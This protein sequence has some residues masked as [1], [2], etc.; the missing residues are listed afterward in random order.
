MGKGEKYY[1]SKILVI[2]EDGQHKQM[3]NGY[4]HIKNGVVEGLYQSLTQDTP[5]EDLGNVA[6]IPGFVNLHT[7]PSEVYGGKSYREDIGNPLFY[8]SSL[9]D[10]ADLVQLGTDSAEIQ[11]RLNLAELIKSGCTTALIFG[12]PN[13]KLEAELAGELGIRAYVGAGIRAGDANEEKSIWNSPDGYSLKYSF[14]EAEGFKRLAEAADSIKEYKNAWNGRVKFLLAPTQSMTCTPE[15]LKETRR[16]ADKLGVGITIHGAED[17]MEFE[18]AIRL[19]GKTPVELM[20]E[21][22]LLGE[23]L[24][25]A[26]CICITGHT[27][28]NI[29]GRDLALLGKS[30]STVA[31]CPW[32]LA[33]EGD[34][35]QSFAK[36]Q[37]AGVNMGIG[38]DTFPS[39]FIQEMRYAAAMGKIADK[40]TFAVSAKKI[41]DAATIGGA[42]AFGRTDIGRLALGAKADFSV[43]KLNNIEMSPVRD[44]A[45]NIIY[46]ATRHSVERVYVDGECIMRDGKVKGADED[47]L[48]A[49]L[50]ELAEKAWK[51]TSIN[52]RHAR[53]I[54]ELSPLIC[55]AFKKKEDRKENA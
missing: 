33:K 2:W 31:H 6:I 43:I 51:R 23:D 32:A 45:K 54:D 41:F 18:N 15:M 12:G 37:S 35:L 47:G 29:S 27:Q 55:P 13:S 25:I 17:F 8:G 30:H 11:A 9:Y 16:Q 10:Y 34:L 53:T 24:V 40:S 48:S 26:H 42:K 50:Q 36:Y 38:T 19:Y 49:K 39:D 20:A 28:I 3:E 4:L 7:H 1:K 46:S 5:F 52:D 14:D 22:G 44:V 21:T